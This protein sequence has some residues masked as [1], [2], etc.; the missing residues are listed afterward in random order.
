MPTVAEYERALRKIKR[1]GGR[2][3]RFLQAHYDAPGMAL[4]MT[5]LADAASYRSY[6]GVNL[7]YGILANSIGRALGLRKP[8]I[9][10]VAELIRPKSVS[11]AEWILILK[12]NLAAAMKRVGWVT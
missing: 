9:G 10:V 1:P 3:P 8:H 4:T 11:N 12:P 2:Q 6:D 5:R 7:R